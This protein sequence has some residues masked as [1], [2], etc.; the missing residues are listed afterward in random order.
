M[1]KINLRLW[2][3]ISAISLALSCRNNS[4]TEAPHEHGPDPLAY[5]LYSEKC[6]L[7]VEFQPLVVGNQTKFAAH[8]TVLGEN[9][10]ALS[11]GKVT[12]S[13]VVNG[14]GIRQTA[15]TPSSPGIYRL[16]LTP[17]VEGKGKLIF[18]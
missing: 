16:A 18:E 3:M 1:C 14:K 2:L 6:E 15:N 12:V 17:N 13:L 7:F 9:F 5:T 8:F 4:A 10:S 11:E